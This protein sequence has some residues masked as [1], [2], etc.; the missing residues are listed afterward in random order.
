MLEKIRLSKS[1]PKCPLYRKK[2]FSRVEQG[3]RI[4]RKPAM[5]KSVPGAALRLV[6]LNLTG[7]QVSGDQHQREA[8][9]GGGK[10][11]VRLRVALSD[12]TKLGQASPNKT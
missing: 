5:T 3:F 1:I 6:A 8:K 7:W 11:T 12:D 4:L 2:L 10:Q 9:R